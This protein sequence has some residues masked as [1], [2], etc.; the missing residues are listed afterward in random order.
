MAKLIAIGAL[1]IWIRSRLAAPE[2]NV[3]ALEAGL[4]KPT[5]ERR[6]NICAEI[7]M[8]GCSRLIVAQNNRERVYVFNLRQLVSLRARPVASN[9]I[10]LIGQL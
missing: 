4:R 8:G 3:V 2:F 9:S 6:L 5:R 7:A 1:L 10:Q